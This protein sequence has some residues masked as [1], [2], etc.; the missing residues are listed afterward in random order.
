MPKAKVT[1]LQTQHLAHAEKWVVHK[2]LRHHAE[3]APRLP[4]VLCHVVAENSDAAG[5]QARE[6]GEDIDERRFAGA[7]WP[8]QAEELTALDIEIDTLQGMHILVAF[9]HAPNRNRSGHIRCWNLAARPAG[10]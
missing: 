8:E 5:I 3:Y 4:V 6:T 2:L 7:I 10:H 9:V 1:G